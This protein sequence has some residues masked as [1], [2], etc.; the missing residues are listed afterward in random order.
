MAYDTTLPVDNSPA[1]SAFVTSELLIVL[2]LFGI[3]L[4]GAVLLTR[5]L[6]LGWLAS[7]GLVAAVLILIY[8]GLSLL[9]ASSRRKRP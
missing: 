6:H 2:G 3:G 4:I 8:L 5:W 9:D 1:S 7:S